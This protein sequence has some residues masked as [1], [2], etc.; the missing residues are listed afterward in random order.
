V[1]PALL[2]DRGLDEAIRRVTTRSSIPVDLKVRDVGRYTPE[3]ESAVYFCV[4]EALQNVLKHAD[5][6]R[7]VLVRVDGG[8]PTQL[9]FSVRD[10]G[11]G[12]SDDRI[13]A[14][15]GITNMRDRLAAVGGEVTITSLRAVGTA[16]RGRVPTQ[17]QRVD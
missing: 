16:V 12:A 6:A 9:R 8:F 7:H 1:Y 3:V 5:G 15:A 17:A 2:A 13:T 10:D 14:G 11:S 4:M